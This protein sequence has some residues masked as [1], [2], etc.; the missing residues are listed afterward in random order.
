MPIYSHMQDV[1]KNHDLP[2]TDKIG[3]CLTC[4]YWQVEQPRDPAIKENLALCLHPD[5]QGYALVVS[6]TSACNVW[7]KKEGVEEEAVEYS[8]IGEPVEHVEEPEKEKQPSE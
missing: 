6:G 2:K 7:K 5:L 1:R 4:T 8:K 3:V